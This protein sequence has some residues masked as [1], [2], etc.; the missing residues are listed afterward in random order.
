[1]KSILAE[2]NISC[3]LTLL[4]T[5]MEKSLWTNCAEFFLC[6][7]CVTLLISFGE[8]ILKREVK[9]SWGMLEHF[10]HALV[11]ECLME[12]VYMS[13][14]SLHSY[15]WT[16]FFFLI[17]SQQKTSKL[18]PLNYFQTTK[19]GHAKQCTTVG[20]KEG[21]IAAVCSNIIK[22]HLQDKKILREEHFWKLEGALQSM[23]LGL[24]LS[25][26]K[27]CTLLWIWDS[28]TQTDAI[29]LFTIT[30]NNRTFECLHGFHRRVQLIQIQNWAFP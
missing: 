3:N 25:N 8:K 23:L 1:M 7:F 30:S 20:K 13:C 12:Y 19:E 5:Y 4:C 26:Y 27:G 6:L 2:Q 10:A 24:F 11:K 28:P 16:A 21:K 15:W 14:V 17:K 18:L 22:R 9:V 29:I